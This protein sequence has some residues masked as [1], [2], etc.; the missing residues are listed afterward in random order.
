M[1]LARLIGNVGGDV[2]AA[3]IEARRWDDDGRVLI[4]EAIFEYLREERGAVADAEHAD[5]DHR[6]AL[7]S[8]RRG[9]PIQRRTAGSL[10]TANPM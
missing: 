6:R 1:V 3:V 8:A 9:L 10:S 4:E 2:G 5:T 7:A